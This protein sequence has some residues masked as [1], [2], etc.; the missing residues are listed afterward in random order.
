M[1]ISRNLIVV[2]VWK[3]LKLGKKLYYY[4]VV[5]YFILIVVLLGLG[6]VILALFVG[7]KLNKFIV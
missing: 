4:L 3:K 2:Y 1:E 5:I 7:L 6:K